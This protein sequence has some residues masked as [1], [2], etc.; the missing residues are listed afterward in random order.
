MSILP[1]HLLV[2]IMQVVVMFTSMNII[3]NQ[4]QRTV[5][6]LQRPSILNL[7]FLSIS[8]SAAAMDKDKEQSCTNDVVFSPS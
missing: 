3:D 8:F 2:L 7:S 4:I 5:V 6:Q 1:M